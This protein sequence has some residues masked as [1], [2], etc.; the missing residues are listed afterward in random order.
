MCIVLGPD[1]TSKLAGKVVD[2]GEVDTGGGLFDVLDHDAQGCR[3]AQAQQSTGLN[4]PASAGMRE[5]EA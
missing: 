3:I 1:Q 2:S 5:A 4:A